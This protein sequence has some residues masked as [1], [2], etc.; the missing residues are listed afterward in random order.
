MAQI[1][2]RYVHGAP[3]SRAGTAAGVDVGLRAH[4]LNVYNYLAGGIG[5]AA[6]LAYAVFNLSLIHI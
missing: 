4:M 2:N 3:A 6:L 1:D 5:L